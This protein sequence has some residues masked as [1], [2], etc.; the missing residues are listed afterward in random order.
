[1][2]RT[3]DIHFFFFSNSSLKLD[4]SKS[5]SA[6]EISKTIHDKKSFAERKQYFSIGKKK[7]NQKKK[8]KT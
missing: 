2:I 1:L 7:E 5:D 6:T 4:T 3:I 8:L